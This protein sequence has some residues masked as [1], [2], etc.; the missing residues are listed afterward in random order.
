MK[1]QRFSHGRVALPGRDTPVFVIEGD[2]GTQLD[3]SVVFGG[4]RQPWS[5]QG[6][7][8]DKQQTTAEGRRTF[9]KQNAFQRFKSAGEERLVKIIALH[10]RPL[11]DRQSYAWAKCSATAARY[12]SRK[13]SINSGRSAMA[14]VRR[15]GYA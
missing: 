11:G 8:A 12:A 10:L 6:V 3:L 15:S 7:L 14:A 1:P 13:A 4:L 5:R 9:C 2:D